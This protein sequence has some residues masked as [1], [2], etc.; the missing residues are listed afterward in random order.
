V[1]QGSARIRVTFSAL[2]E[3]QNVDRLL[4]ALEKATRQ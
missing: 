3:E 2:H 4:D 1:P